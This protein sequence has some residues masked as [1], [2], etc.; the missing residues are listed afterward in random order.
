MV[1]EIYE[2]FRE[3][4]IEMLNE[5]GTDAI[6]L[7]PGEKTGPEYRPEIG[8][9]TRQTIR[10]FQTT[11]MLTSQTDPRVTVT[12]NTLLISATA[13]IVI[14]DG[15]SVELGMKTYEIKTVQEIAPVFLTILWKAEIVR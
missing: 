8:P 7:K 5:F 11:K 15:D 4:A 14:D 6:L 12:K 10:V 3:F 2:E 13:G 9:P 1:N